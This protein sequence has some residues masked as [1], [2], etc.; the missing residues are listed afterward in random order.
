MKSFIPLVLLSLI[1]TITGFVAPITWA[2]FINQ[3]TF[4]NYTLSLGLLFGLLLGLCGFWMFCESTLYTGL[5]LSSASVLGVMST[6]FLG[7]L[8]LHFL[9][10]PVVGLVM[11]IVLGVGFYLITLKILSQKIPQ[12]AITA[13]IYL[14]SIALTILLSNYSSQGHHEM[15]NALFGNSVTVLE[16]EFNPALIL[17]F[18][19]LFTTFFLGKK[20]LLMVF[21]PLFTKITNPKKAS[22]WDMSQ[23]GFILITLACASKLFGVLNTFSL[24][25]FASLSSIGFLKSGFKSYFLSGLYGIVLFPA[26]FLL[27]FFLDLPTGACITL[28]GFSLFAISQTVKRI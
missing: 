6:H 22:L 20:W 10:G 4:W 16:S 21:D 9:E 13:L 24:L 27:S 12:G 11:S 18:S 8:G 14:V 3:I 15:E 1:V 7:E 17:G 23:L 19:L 5:S 25:L 26:G 28:A 2:D